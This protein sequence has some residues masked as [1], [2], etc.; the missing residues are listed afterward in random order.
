MAPFARN[1]G[2]EVHIADVLDARRW[3]DLYFWPV[4]DNLAAVPH[5]RLAGKTM[6]D[7]IPPAGIT[8]ALASSFASMSRHVGIDFAL[9]R[10]TMPPLADGARLGDDYDV[11]D[12]R[13]PYVRSRLSAQGYQ[14]SLPP[15]VVSVSRVRGVL[16]GDTLLDID[17]DDTD[18]GEIVP[19]NRAQGAYHVR[20]NTL[21]TTVQ[22]GWWTM[23][24]AFSAT[25]P[26][27]WAVDYVTGYVSA[28]SGRAGYVPAD[29]ADYACLDAGIQLLN[30]AGT[31]ATKGVS[32][33][34]LG[35]DGFSKSVS[36][37]ASAMYGVNSALE[38]AF[39]DRM[40][41]IDLEHARAHYRGIQVGRFGG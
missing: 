19:V 29:L 22:G 4:L 34:S 15:N 25:V 36:L 40:Q 1:F 30:M 37:Q 41:R 20:P 32:S 6:L 16:F 24:A 33:T 7:A 2:L 39:T 17:A 31:M 35:F 12:D 5:P 9:V 10:H 26:A 8:N 13:L 18:T 28:I 14:L 23:L 21:T 38:K 27:F 3:R 11:V